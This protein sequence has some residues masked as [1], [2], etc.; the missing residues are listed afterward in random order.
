VR[1]LRDQNIRTKVTVLSSNRSR[2]GIPFGR[3][4]LSHLL[5]NR[6]FVG[7]VAYKGEILPGEQPA[8]IERALFDAVQQKLSDQQ[9]HTILTRQKAEHL[10]D[11]GNRAPAG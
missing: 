10:V 9:S 7:E 6:F 3:G 5:R 1:A 8:I 11:A 4:M 2:G